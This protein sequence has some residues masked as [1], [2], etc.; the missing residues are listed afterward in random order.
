MDK[1]RIIKQILDNAEEKLSESRRV[2]EDTREQLNEAPGAMQSKSDT[3]GQRLSLAVAGF[4]SAIRERE[5]F[6]EDNREN[7]MV[8]FFIYGSCRNYR[9]INCPVKHG[10]CLVGILYCRFI[11]ISCKIH[12]KRAS[13]LQRV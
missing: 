2:L 5:R 7:E 11:R 12:I 13:P 10:I 4:E 9:W 1:E 8:F 3:S 6:Q